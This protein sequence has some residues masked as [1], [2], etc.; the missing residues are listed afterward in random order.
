VRSESIVFSSMSIS[1]L[2]FPGAKCVNSF[3]FFWKKIAIFH[4]GNKPSSP[5]A[6]WTDFLQALFTLVHLRRLDVPK[7][8]GASKIKIIKVVFIRQRCI[9]DSQVD[10]YAWGI[11]LQYF[12]Y[13]ESLILQHPSSPSFHQQINTRSQIMMTFLLMNSLHI[14]L[15]FLSRGHTLWTKWFPS[16]HQENFPP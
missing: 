15:F 12:I 1:F 8:H 14:D 7:C 6:I 11:Y 13:T 5:V 2:E 9:E 3:C 16:F 10:F 4:K